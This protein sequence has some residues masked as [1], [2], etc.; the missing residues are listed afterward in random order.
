MRKLFS[1]SWK[2][3]DRGRKGSPEC[4]FCFQ[5][6]LAIPMAHQSILHSL[7][8]QAISKLGVLPSYKTIVRI[9]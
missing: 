9:K 5:Y 3:E 4:R 2:E 8:S 1:K 6:L 7:A